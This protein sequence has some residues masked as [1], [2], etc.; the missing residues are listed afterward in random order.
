MYVVLLSMI[1]I[2]HFAMTKGYSFPHDHSQ[3]H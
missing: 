3:Q 1:F 2:I